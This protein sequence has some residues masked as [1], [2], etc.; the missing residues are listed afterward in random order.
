MTSGDEFD[1]YTFVTY[2]TME[3][4]LDKVQYHPRLTGVTKQFKYKS[5]D[6]IGRRHDNPI[7]DSI[8]Y[9][10]EFSDGEKMSF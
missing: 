7:L 6:S 10:V 8:I 9:E 1:P 2:I 5:G 3:V 4:A